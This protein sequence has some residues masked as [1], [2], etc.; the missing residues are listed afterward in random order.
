MNTRRMPIQEEWWA[1]YS[2]VPLQMVGISAVKDPGNTSCC[3]MTQQ[4]EDLRIQQLL[5]SPCPE[6]VVA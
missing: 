2:F 5:P 1:R 4:K 3:G 6:K